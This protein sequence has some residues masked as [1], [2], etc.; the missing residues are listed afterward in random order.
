MVETKT[1]RQS[2]N[3]LGFLRGQL[4]GLQG[5]PTLCYELIQNADD[6]KDN[7][8]NPAATRIIFDVCD[9]AL[10]V[11]NDGVFRDIDFERMEKVSWGNKREEEGTTGAFGLGFISVYQITDS[12]EIFSSG[13]HWQFVPNGHEDERIR[14]TLMETKETKFRLP[15]A[16]EES[17][18][19]KEL[20]IQPVSRESLSD[21]AVQINHSIESAALFLKQ[22]TTLELRRNGKLIRKIEAVRESDKLL[23]ADGSQTVIWRIFE[24]SFEASA[25]EMRRRYGGIIET[26]R[27]PIVKIAVPDDPEVNGLLY[28]F[29]PSETSTGLP[30]HINA[31][32]YPS[33]DRKRIIF[34]DGFKAEWNELAI[35]CATVTLARHC[36]EFLKIFSQKNFWEF[37]ERIKKA[38]IKDEL[39]PEFSRFWELLKPQ[40][41]NKKSVLTSSNTTVLPTDAIFLDTRELIN[42]EKILENLGLNIVHSDLRS[43]QNLLLETGVQNLRL[44]DICNSFV[45]NNLTQRQEISSM[46][47]G[48]NTLEGWI[49]LW[50]ALEN[51]WNRSYANDRRQN[52]YLLKKI[53]IAFGTDGGLWPPEELFIA[54][55]YSQDFFSKINEVVW[56][57][58]KTNNLSF[59]NELIPQFTLADGLGLLKEAENSLPDYWRGEIFSPEEILEWFEKR[60]SEINNSSV[61]QMR[62]L[63]I[64]PTAE[65]ELKSLTD[66]YLAGDFEDPL[67]LAQLVDL[68]ALGG[69]RD[70][71]ERVLDVAQLDF[72]TYVRD[73]VPSVIKKRELKLDER[74]KLIRILAENLGKLRDHPEIRTI[75]EGLPIVWCGGEEFCWASIVWFDTNEVRDVLGSEIKLARLPGEKSEAIRELYLWIGVSPEP[76]PKDIVNRIL[77]IVKVVPNSDSLQLIGRLIDFIA[78][79]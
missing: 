9:D 41:K 27:Q 20:G 54:D 34:G 19:R 24:G 23:L 52:H 22:V 14:E 47:E 30:F 45:E 73:W 10:F 8:G 35:Q 48:L 5:I 17:E 53:S 46:P 64:W 61:Q 78:S 55:Q 15:W 62:A 42:A 29:L 13:R 59:F 2:V 72:I 21:F 63:S 76:E 40:I 79:K 26:K 38:S 69:G 67:R 39:S 51:L 70:F 3:F 11:Y 57:Q 12:P 49:T 37:A 36:D 65:G 50:N 16:F 71:L 68:D 33:P 31:D 1:R 77:K 4:N 44:S 60:R 75:L 43:R 25:N 66:L 74:F 56:Y 28:A 7:N 18:V 6:V 32:F 58:A